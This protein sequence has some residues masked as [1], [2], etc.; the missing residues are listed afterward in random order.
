[1]ILDLICLE[2]KWKI[3]QRRQIYHSKYE[4]STQDYEILCKAKTG[5][6]PKVYPTLIQ[7]ILRVDLHTHLNVVFKIIILTII[8]THSNSSFLSLLMPVNGSRHRIGSI[9]LG[10]FEF[11]TS[12]T[13][14]L[15][16]QN[17]V[18]E[19]EQFYAATSE[20]FQIQ[21]KPS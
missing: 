19:S 7:G 8:Q 9:G 10:H 18:K 16:Q 5:I 20:A 17:L 14:E 2:Y 13:E 11:K 3:N 6:P 21:P 4:I 12:L 15:I 1:V